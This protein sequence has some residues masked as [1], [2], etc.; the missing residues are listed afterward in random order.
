[1]QLVV[2]LLVLV[3][4]VLLDADAAICS[5]SARSSI[6][7]VSTSSWRSS[8]AMISLMLLPPSL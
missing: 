6:S 5:T 8:W 7:K 4:L 2:L 3:L 1:V